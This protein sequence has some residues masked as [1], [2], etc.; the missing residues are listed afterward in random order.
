MV[1]SWNFFIIVDAADIPNENS[2]KNNGMVRLNLEGILT[3][4]CLGSSEIVNPT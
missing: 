1:T 2:S 4:V 3:F